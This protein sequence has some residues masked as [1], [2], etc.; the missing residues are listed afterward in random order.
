MKTIYVIMIL[1]S[2]NLND[3]LPQINNFSINFDGRWKVV[4][5]KNTFLQLGV[6]PENV[7]K[8]NKRKI[9]KNKVFAFY[10]NYFICP[11]NLKNTECYSDTVF[12][13]DEYILDLKD[14][15]EES[16]L[17]PGN[18]LECNKTG[19]EKGDC[20]VGKT[21]MKLLGANMKQ[22]HIITGIDNYNYKIKYGYTNFIICIINQSKIGLYLCNCNTLLI[23]EKMK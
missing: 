21:F 6:P 19:Y 14:D 12:L 17:H 9:Y 18:E 16:F 2:I 1:I 15:T 7:E 5:V 23:L 10:N 3:I 22:L 13:K 4:E 8:I 11:L 20:F